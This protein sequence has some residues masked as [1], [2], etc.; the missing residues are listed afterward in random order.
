MISDARNLSDQDSNS[1]DLPVTNNEDKVPNEGSYFLPP[2]PVFTSS[3]D[4]FGAF[5]SVVYTKPS[6]NP[7]EYESKEN[8]TVIEKNK[9]QNHKEGNEEEEKNHAVKQPSLVAKPEKKRIGKEDTKKRAKGHTHL[10]QVVHTLGA[11]KL[12]RP[13]VRSWT[14]RSTTSDS[15]KEGDPLEE[16]L[17]LMDGNEASNKGKSRGSLKDSPAASSLHG[18]P[19]NKTKYKVDLDK[20]IESLTNSSSTKIRESASE[21][22]ADLYSKESNVLTETSQSHESEQAAKE[23]N[24]VGEK[25]NVKG[26]VEKEIIENEKNLK[27]DVNDKDKP[28]ESDTPDS[29]SEE[30]SHDGNSVDKTSTDSDSEHE[31]KRHKK[32]RKRSPSSSSE[33]DRSHHRKKRKKYHKRRRKH[34]RSKKHRKHRDR[35]S[36]SSENE[37]ELKDDKDNDDEN[38][39]DTTGD[40]LNDE[41]DKSKKHKKHKKKSKHHKKS[42]YK[43]KRGKSK[44]KKKSTKSHSRSRSSSRNRSNSSS[45]TRSHSSSRHRSR[46]S[47]KYQ[48]RSSSG[49]RSRSSSKHRSRCLNNS[50]SKSPCKG[51]GENSS[52]RSRSR[53][54]SKNRYTCKPRH[55]G[56]SDSKSQNESSSKHRSRS[57]SKHRSRSSSKHRSRSSSK[58]RSSSR[59]RSRSSSSSSDSS[60]KYRSRSVSKTRS[61]SP[62]KSNNE[63]TKQ[64]NQSRSRSKTGYTHRSRQREESDA[65]SSSESSSKDT[66]RS[67]STSSNKRRS[68]S[69]SRNRSKS[70]SKGR[71]ENIN[72]SRS[73]SRS[74]NSSAHKAQQRREADSRSQIESFSRHRSRSSSRHR[75][76]SSSKCKSK[77]V[78]KNRSRSPSKGREGKTIRRS[79]SCSRSKVSITCKSQG[80]KGSNLS[81]KESQPISTPMPIDPSKIK[82]EKEEIVPDLSI[83]KTE[84]LDPE[85]SSDIYSNVEKLSNNSE[86]NR[87]SNDMDNKKIH[88][89]NQKSSKEGTK[90]SESVRRR[91]KEQL[92]L[93]TDKENKRRG[94]RERKN[95]TESKT[96][97]ESKRR[98]SCERKNSTESITDKESKRRGSHERKNS[99]ESI[100]EKSSTSNRRGSIDSK[101]SDSE[102]S[103]EKKKLDDR[104]MNTEKNR[105]ENVSSPNPD[106]HPKDMSMFDMV[107]ASTQPSKPK[108]LTE[109]SIFEAA[110]N[111]HDMSADSSTSSDDE[112]D[113]NDFSDCRAHKSSTQEQYGDKKHNVSHSSG[114]GKTEQS[115]K[116]DKKNDLPKSETTRY[117]HKSNDSHLDATSKENKSESKHTH[118]SST[119]DK[120]SNYLI[121]SSS[122][123][124]SSSSHHKSSSSTSGSSSSSKQHHSSS[125]IITSTSTKTIHSSNYKSKEGNSDITSSSHIRSSSKHSSSKHHHSSKN[126]SSR[127]TSDSHHKDKGTSSS[128]TS[129]SRKENKTEVI[130]SKKAAKADEVAKSKKTAMKEESSD[131]ISDR[132]LYGY[133]DTGNESP[134]PDLSVLDE[135]PED[136]WEQMI[137][138]SDKVNSRHFENLENFEESDEEGLDRDDPQVMEECMKMFNDYQPAPEDLETQPSSKKTRMKSVDEEPDLLPGK[139]RIARSSSTG[140]LLPKKPNLHQHRKTPTQMMMERYKKLKEQQAELM[141]QLEKQKQQLEEQSRGGSSS[142]VSSSTSSKPTVFPASSS[143]SIMSPPHSS[144]GAVKRRISHVPNVSS[145]LHAREKIKNLPPANSRTL[146]SPSLS[147]ASG[148]IPQ[149]HSQTVPRGEKRI[150]HTA[151]IETL[152]RPVIQ[153]EFGSK[154]P[155]NIRQ[156]YLNLFTDECLKF[157]GEKEAFS[158]A[159]AEECVCVKRAS[160]RMVYL[161]LAVNAVKRL[162]TQQKAGEAAQELLDKD[163]QFAETLSVEEPS[164]SGISSSPS[165]E[166]KS[167]PTN[168]NHVKLSHFTVLAGGGQRGSWSIEKSK[169]NPVDIQDSLK[170]EAFY[171][172]LVKYILTEKQLDENGYPCPDPD[173]KGKAIVKVVD[174]RKKISPSS[175][176]R[177]CDRCS[178]LYVV[179]K[180]GFPTSTGP[181]V[182]H[183]GRAYKRRSYGGPEARYSCCG[184]DL[185]SEGCCQAVTHVS[186][187]YNPKNLHGYVRTLPKDIKGNDHGVYALDCEMCYTTSGIELTRVTVVNTEGNTV[188]ENLVKPE[189]PIIDYNTRFSGITE[190]DLQDV[191]TTLLDVQAALLTRFSDKT[192]LIGHSLESDFQALKLIHDTVV[193]TSVV[194]PHKMGAPYKRALRNLASEYLKKIIQND[195]SGHDSA[196]DATT[197]M[198]L[199]QWKVKEDIKGMK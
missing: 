103:Y 35:K 70:P 33:S 8:R 191:K 167:H 151:K 51:R 187:N 23:S 59:H 170:G 156:R 90:N 135:I 37:E 20:E 123:H 49:H 4:G 64:R 32:K 82:V 119:K 62:F 83:V 192:I 97:K 48:S 55:K 176:E 65:E 21:D 71:G 46:S 159:A 152:A 99:T 178:V 142:T 118:S 94:I 95:S 148:A 78:K 41:S 181:C 189:N 5:N 1:C 38:K 172:H 108:S 169:K 112:L 89:G 54:R 175:V 77:S 126:S 132:D 105:K 121:S 81:A 185:E 134:L 174:S 173:E 39:S 56:E 179:D 22:K 16:M 58:H 197:C 186:Q 106:D 116:F 57:S 107:F 117:S 91:E 177:Y 102:T 141:K 164:T 34:G 25:V 137:S 166:G 52:Q 93:T 131:G 111:M 193:D 149:T 110:S 162:R 47:S 72:R 76:R 161:N 68:R 87:K 88:L 168:P 184:G 31:K 120:S 160:S 98:G 44:L 40:I 7:D 145:L 133:N 92:R 199:M 158:I 154:V 3:S 101:K 26:N 138:S 163:P 144:P 19:K 136:D 11:P 86:V 13:N 43:R 75:S 80:R 60:R 171:K 196:E 113:Q 6:T 183:W 18:S 53:S 9:G 27:M 36:D 129:R 66:S 104:R 73:H 194:F 147:K 195:V 45:S 17:Q 61:K 182:Y 140:N 130:S 153:T 50:R 157:C 139:Q 198:Y 15:K 125:V 188:Y 24:Q 190:S 127:Q 180:W 146:L 63:N 79:R 109:I 12:S 69:L 84:K 115:S 28:S 2:S 10:P 74:K 122:H 85:E 114:K 128:K 143:T 124:S 29:E 30:E 155:Q 42:K 150:A 165:K 14:P 100:T 67:S 96:D